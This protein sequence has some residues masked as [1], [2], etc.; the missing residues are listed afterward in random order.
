M[1]VKLI[2]SIML[3]TP[4]WVKSQTIIIINNG[5]SA[6]VAKALGNGIQQGASAATTKDK[7]VTEDV[8]GV[9]MSLVGIE[10]TPE[11]FVRLTNVNDFKVTVTYQFNYGHVSDKEYKATI[12]LNPGE[13]KETERYYYRP[14]NLQCVVKEVKVR[15]ATSAKKQR[16]T[17]NYN[18]RIKHQ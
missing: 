5:D 11:Y 7:P 13:W 16:D 6:N 12:V 1:K 14:T 17:F 10:G 18:S 8:G 4:L 3:L 2:L 15:E 9:D